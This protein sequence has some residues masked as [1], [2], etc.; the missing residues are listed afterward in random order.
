M[1]RTQ[2]VSLVAAL[3]DVGGEVTLD[4][5]GTLAGTGTLAPEEHARVH[6]ALANGR[7]SIPSTVATLSGERGT[8]R[9]TSDV[10][11]FR[12]AAPIGT[13]VLETQPTLRWTSAAGATSYVV[14]L[15]NEESGQTTSSPPIADTRWTSENALA[16]GATYSWQVVARIGMTETMAPAPPSPPTRF[17]IATAA[18]AARFAALPPSHLVRGVACASAGMLDE[19]ERELGALA[20]ANPGSPLVERLLGQLRAARQ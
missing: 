9:G 6:D 18:E 11:V 10:V 3:A 17:R 15:Q 19:A 5:R 4:A 12:L 1:S 16:Q 13:V 14:T 8:L 20:A 7:L 2:P